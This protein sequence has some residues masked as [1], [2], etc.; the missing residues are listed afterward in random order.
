[1]ACFQ[2]LEHE[3]SWEGWRVGIGNWLVTSRLVFLLCRETNVTK[4]KVVSEFGSGFI[5]LG[6]W[7][8]FL[9]RCIYLLDW[10]WI[11]EHEVILDSTLITLCISLGC[12]FLGVLVFTRSTHLAIIVMTIV[13]TIVVGLLFFMVIATWLKSP[14]VFSLH[15]FS[16]ARI[17][18]TWIRFILGVF[19]DDYCIILNQIW[20]VWQMYLVAC[21]PSIVKRLCFSAVL[22]ICSD[23]ELVHRRHRSP[24][25]HRFCGF[26]GGLLP[27]FVT[28]SD[29]NIQENH[30]TS[31]MGKTWNL[32]LECPIT[33]SYI[34]ELS[35]IN[36]NLICWRWW[37]SWGRINTIPAT[38]LTSRRRMMRKKRCHLNTPRGQ[39]Q[40][41]I[42]VYYD[43]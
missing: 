15:E 23:H 28:V 5:A 1:M 37:L 25:P 42:L 43:T 12:V 10:F 13:M 2:T 35:E 16:I 32:K 22:P 26:R 31:G 8:F 3:R 11:S 9:N 40:S 27:P 17:F 18:Y 14:K 4:V 6:F 19:F 20:Q 7:T 39:T 36:S 30:T 24:I 33:G 34:S 38:S 41:Y 29:L 21:F